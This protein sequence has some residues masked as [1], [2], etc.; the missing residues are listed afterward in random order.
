MT[1]TICKKLLR[2][3]N[4]HLN[5][6]KAVQFFTSSDSTPVEPFTWASV[7]IEGG[8]EIQL[9]EEQQ[10]KRYLSY[11]EE[12]IG[13]VLAEK[14]LCVLG[15]ERNAHLLDYSIPHCNIDLV[16]RADILVLS[17]IAKKFW[18]SCLECGY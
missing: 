2:A 10:R 5:F 16:G 8:Q 17:D 18:S 3:L 1:S 15:V 11:V 7:F 12:N 4:I 6:V 14:K 9:T 13:T